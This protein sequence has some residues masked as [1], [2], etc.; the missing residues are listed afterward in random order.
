MQG[1]DAAAI[2]AVAAGLARVRDG[3]GRLFI[4]GVGGSAG[5]ASHAVNDFRKL[6]AFEAYTPTDNV[7]ELTARVNDEG[8]DGS[9]AAWLEVSRMGP[10]DAVL[11]FSVGGGNK[12]KNVSANLVR[13]LELAAGA[14][15]RRVRRRRPRRRRDARGGG[16]VRRHPDRVSRPHHAAHRGTVR[17][18]LA[19]AGQPPR[20]QAGGH[21]VGIDQV[22][23]QGRAS[24]FRA[25]ARARIP[26]L[27]VLAVGVLL[28]LSMAIW[29]DAR[30]GFDYN[31]HW[32]H[33]QYIVTHHALPPL[34]FNTTA[35]HPPLY[36]AIAAAIVALGL[37]AGALGWLSALWGMLRL[38]L[39]WIGLLRWLPESRLAAP[40]QSA[41]V[42][43]PEKT[44]VAHRA[45]GA[46]RLARV[47]ALALAAVV[48]AAA[49]LDGMI[50]NETLVMLLSAG[51]LVVAPGAIA[52]A[53]AGRIRPMVGLALLLGL[54]MMAKVSA[55]VLVTSVA[56]AIVLEIARAGKAWRKA[57]RVRARPL[58]AGALVL[59][60][61]RGAVL[62]AQPRSL[63]P[64]RPE[65]LR[66]IAEARTRRRTR[67]S[68]T[69]TA[70]RSRFYVGWNLGIYVPPAVSDRLK[71]NARFFPV[72]IA[73]T[74]NDYYVFSYSGGGKYH[75]RALG[76]GRRR[77]ARLPVDRGGD[78]SSRWSR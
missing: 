32:P 41:G 68:R 50:T 19:P 42:R 52:A 40:A 1:L 46:E 61:D 7:S 43:P 22:G 76:L 48:P 4:L 38:V 26:E 31:A 25:W 12:E 11:V 75:E 72:L 18:R 63:R 5:H 69:S 30:I 16:S 10:R 77:H 28:R 58:I 64:D 67:R 24:R 2:D 35:P 14:G 65:R 44:T 74:F 56:V 20:A 6:C 21:Q 8:W 9:F 29:Y 70:G 47:V 49:H 54:A 53:R 45:F 55:S 51:V 36:H 39:I 78:A 62:R 59:A 17:G 66:G 71:P 3:G 37:D 57:L 34:D 60:V 33:I 23:H 27:V 13:A 73:T 15:Q